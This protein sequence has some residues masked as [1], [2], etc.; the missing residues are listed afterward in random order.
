MEKA[1]HVGGML[2]AIHLENIG[3]EIRDASNLVVGRKIQIPV[4]GDAAG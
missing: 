1:G 4:H 3:D 2:Y